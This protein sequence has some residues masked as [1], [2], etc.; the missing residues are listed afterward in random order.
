MENFTKRI[1]TKEL[2]RNFLNNTCSHDQLEEIVQW[3]KDYHFKQEVLTTLKEEWEAL[4]DDNGVVNDKK[5][6]AL[7]DKLHHRINLAHSQIFSTEVQKRTNRPILTWLTRAAAI[8]FL[9]LL[10]VMTFTLTQPNF[11]LRTFS[12]IPIDSIEIIAPAGSRTFVQLDDGSEVY[13]NHGSKLKYPHKFVGSTREVRL[14][15]EGYFTVAHNPENPFIVRARNVNV[16]AVGT[17]FNVYAYPNEKSIETTLVNGKVIVGKLTGKGEVQLIESM[18]P[19][20]HLSFHPAKSQYS[21]TK[22]EIEKYISWKDGRL[23]FKNDPIDHIANRLSRW[24]NVDIEFENEQVKDFTYTAT[25]MDETLTQILNLL[26][27]AT[28]IDYK[29]IPG[30]KQKDGTYTKQKVTIGMKRQQT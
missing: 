23:V 9:P 30:K 17:E 12:S 13:L 26:K 4:A 10:A 15:G 25:F 2:L 22:G 20:E 28:P 18:N 1:M 3:V 6:T 8:L 5:R 14:T 16:R 11:D 24:Y 7:L 29:I 21:S 19:G 27:L